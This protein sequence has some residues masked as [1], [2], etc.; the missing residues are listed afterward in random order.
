M[1]YSAGK[2][3]RLALSPGMHAIAK[4][5]PPPNFFGLLLLERWHAPPSTYQ[6]YEGDCNKNNL[7][8]RVKAKPSS[9]VGFYCREGPLMQTSVL[10]CKRCRKGRRNPLDTAEV[11]NLCPQSHKL[12]KCGNTLRVYH[13]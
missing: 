10:A 3:L 2:R 9:L 6:G 1:K 12:G 4:I 13:I 8:H 5:P 11:W 7:C